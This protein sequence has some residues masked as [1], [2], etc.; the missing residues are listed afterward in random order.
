MILSHTSPPARSGVSL[1]L[2]PQHPLLV[3]GFLSLI[4]HLCFAPTLNSHPGVWV[5]RKAH[6]LSRPYVRTDSPFTPALL[7]DL[8]LLSFYICEH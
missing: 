6:H 2:V 4:A 8:S 7:P 5:H 3:F 1:L